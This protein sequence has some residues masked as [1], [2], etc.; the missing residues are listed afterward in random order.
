MTIKQIKSKI[1]SKVKYKAKSMF[2]Q[3]LSEL[4]KVIQREE[5][6]VEMLEQGSLENGVE[7]MV[8]KIYYYPE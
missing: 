7:F 5:T 6:S 3:S 2:F 8:V 1:Q 4:T